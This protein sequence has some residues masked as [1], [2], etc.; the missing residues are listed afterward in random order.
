MKEFAGDV[1][2]FSE[3]T[4]QFR[5]HFASAREAFNMVMAEL[6]LRQVEAGTRRDEPITSA[7][8]IL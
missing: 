3:R 2:E 5:I 1:L 8:R 7:A 4:G 6:I